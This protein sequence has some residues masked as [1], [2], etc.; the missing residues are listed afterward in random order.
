MDECATDR[1][2][3]RSSLSCRGCSPAGDGSRSSSLLTRCC[4]GIASC[5]DESGAAG[6]DNAVPVV[7]HL[8]TTSSS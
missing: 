4:A 5:P 3:G 2:T 1:R 7:R 6:D 8:L